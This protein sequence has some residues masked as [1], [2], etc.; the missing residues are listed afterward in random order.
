M[1]QKFII[2]YY[3][4]L[5]EKHS[6]SLSEERIPF[7]CIKIPFP[8]IKIPCLCG[9][10]ILSPVGETFNQR[11]GKTASKSVFCVSVESVIR[12]RETQLEWIEFYVDWVLRWIA[13][14]FAT[15]YKAFNCKKINGRPKVRSKKFTRS[16]RENHLFWHYF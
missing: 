1:Q 9:K 5:R 2:V 16:Q 15:F 3:W 7:L 6:F 4:S 14:S 8:C 13:T 10:M 11:S 12:W